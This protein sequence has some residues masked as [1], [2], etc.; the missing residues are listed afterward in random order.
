MYLNI[1]PLFYIIYLSACSNV[2]NLDIY[3]SV[4]VIVTLA[5]SLTNS[6]LAHLL[7]NRAISWEACN[8]ALICLIYVNSLLSLVGIFEI[9]FDNLSAITLKFLWYSVSSLRSL[10][11]LAFSINLFSYSLISFNSPV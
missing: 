2:F 8:M 11:F 6:L 3:S 7:S 10:V 5:I 9:S 4:L 1:T